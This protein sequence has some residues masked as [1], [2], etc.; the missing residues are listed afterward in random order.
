MVW[1]PYMAST[2][3]FSFIQ[4]PF[5][6]KRERERIILVEWLLKKQVVLDFKD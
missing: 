5:S 1:K 4:E 2:S 6:L 3:C